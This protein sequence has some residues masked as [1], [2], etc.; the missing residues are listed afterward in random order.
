[1]SQG[2]HPSR[3][4]NKEGFLPLE[5]D[6]PAELSFVRAGILSTNYTRFLSKREIIMSLS[7]AAL[8]IDIFTTSGPPNEDGINAVYVFEQ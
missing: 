8:G 2:P 4:L 7:N 6:I 3:F 1:M 5:E